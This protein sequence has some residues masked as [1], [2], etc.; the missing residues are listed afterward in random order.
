M[1]GRNVFNQVSDVIAL[2]EARWETYSPLQRI[3]V[4]S[5]IMGDALAVGPAAR[6]LSEY[7]RKQGYDIPPFPFSSSGEIKQFFAD[8]GVTNVP[9]WYACIGIDE[10]GYERINAS[11][12]VAVR[13][14]ENKRM[15]IQLDGEYH[16]HLTR[17]VPLPQS[18]IVYALGAEKL[19]A[20]LC[21]IMDFVVRGETH[22]RPTF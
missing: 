2:L 10:A 1:D 18:G 20:L 6:Y 9:E 16:K 11:T 4:F 5:F 3:E 7:A 17:F 14:P 13:N 8:W 21:E 22:G 19:D 15:V 12:L